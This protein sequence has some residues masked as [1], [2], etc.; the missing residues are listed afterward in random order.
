M[1]WDASQE[2]HNI[3]VLL[4]FYFSWWAVIHD[5]MS[6]RND[7]IHVEIVSWCMKNREDIALLR[8]QV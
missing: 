6:A 5:E 8:E 7:N 2:I 4:G 1:T 3:S